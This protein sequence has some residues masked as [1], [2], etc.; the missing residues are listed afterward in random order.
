MGRAGLFQG[1]VI[2]QNIL[3]MIRGRHPTATYVPN[4]I[5]EGALK[6]TLGKA[7]SPN[8]EDFFKFFFYRNSNQ[9]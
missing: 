3:A 5:I 1:E 9:S 6:L 7:S 2:V 4:L 8:L